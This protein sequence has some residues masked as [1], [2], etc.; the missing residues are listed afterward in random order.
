MRVLLDTNV[1]LDIALARKPFAKSAFAAYCAVRDAG[2][3]PLVAPHSLA[4]FYYIIAQ[5]NGQKRAREAVN[6]L[7]ATS[8]VAAFNHETALKSQELGFADFEDAMIVATAIA[9][10]AGLI[11]TRNGKDFMQSPVAFASP[12]EFLND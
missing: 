5:A 12:E 9:C 7:I 6:D 10:G 3:L 8:E 11:L 2:E 4:T 1:L